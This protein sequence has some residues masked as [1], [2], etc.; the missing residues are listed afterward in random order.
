MNTEREYTKDEIKA[1]A[2][3]VKKIADKTDYFNKDGRISK[4]KAEAMLA[5]QH[6]PFYPDYL[7]QAQEVVRDYQQFDQEPELLE[8]LYQEN[9]P[10]LLLCKKEKQLFWS[11]DIQRMDYTQKDATVMKAL[12]VSE[13]PC[14]KR[15]V[16]IEDVYKI[17]KEKEIPMNKYESSSES[18]KEYNDKRYI[19]NLF[20]T[21]LHG[22]FLCAIDPHDTLESI[23]TKT[24]NGCDFER[25]LLTF[26]NNF[27]EIEEKRTKNRLWFRNYVSNKSMREY[28]NTLKTMVDN[29]QVRTELK[30]QIKTNLHFRVKTILP[31]YTELKHQMNQ[32]KKEYRE[33]ATNENV[34]K[35]DKIYHQ[36]HPLEDIVKRY[37]MEAKND[38]NEKTI[39]YDAETQTND[40]VTEF[41]SKN[42]MKMSPI[43]GQRPDCT[44]F[45]QKLHIAQGI[46]EGDI[47]VECENGDGFRVNNQLVFVPEGEKT[48]YYRFPT[49]FH[50]IKHKD[51]QIKMESEQW[52]N[53]NFK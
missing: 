37:W 36:L 29:T 17:F 51:K 4:I 18:D 43:L 27:K 47:H 31:R 20:D 2:K 13:L 21:R 14:K 40:T 23:K 5:L 7:Q 3:R 45:D 9:K 44:K 24:A 26:V 53:E 12:G 50:D 52:M 28:Y 35:Q 38:F 48:A 30:T 46:I 42:T 16:I 49:T 8:K 10:T 32:L 19:E 1:I 39:E 22:D 34:A 25:P 41:V 6:E 15:E 33:H 11:S